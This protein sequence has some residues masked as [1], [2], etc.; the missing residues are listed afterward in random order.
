MLAMTCAGIYRYPI[1]GALH[2]NASKPAPLT[3]VAV[4]HDLLPWGFNSGLWGFNSVTRSFWA[5]KGLCRLQRRELPGSTGG[6]HH[7]CQMR[8]VAVRMLL[9]TVLACIS[10]LVGRGLRFRRSDA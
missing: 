3:S 7:A 10:I 6:C 1:A 2:H 4:M 8:N 9:P 5:V